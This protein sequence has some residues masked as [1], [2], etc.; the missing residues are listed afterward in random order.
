[1]TEAD[2]VP[3]KSLNDDFIPPVDPLYVPF[4]FFE[5]MKRIIQ[6][7][8]FFPVY[9]TGLTGNGKTQMIEQTCA[10]AGRELIRANIVKD[11]DEFDLIGNYELID[12]NTIW[13]DGP[14]LIAMKRG[15]ILLLDETDLGSERL[16]C[17]QPILEGKGYFNKKRGEHIRPKKG[18]NVMATANTKGR[19]SDDG[20]YIGTN[21]LNE[22]FLERFSIT[23]YQEYPNPRTETTILMN[24]FSSLETTPG[25]KASQFANNLV[26]WA[27]LIRKSY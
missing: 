17:L 24:L 4:G 2:H 16:L 18:F 8:I 22:A 10:Q 1:M 11:T 3:E 20:K 27:E 26:K 21:V 9:V 6:K 25:M 14:A 19:G 7:E 5:D 15:A 23:V 13:H 12:G